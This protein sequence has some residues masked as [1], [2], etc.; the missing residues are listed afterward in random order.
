VG[1]LLVGSKVGSVEGAAVEGV[2]VGGST[3]ILKPVGREVERLA[4]NGVLVFT[5]SDG[6]VGVGTAEGTAVDGKTTGVFF[7]TSVG[8]R[9]DE[10][11]TDGDGVPW[12]GHA[13]GIFVGAAVMVVGGTVRPALNGVRA[14]SVGL[15]TAGVGSVEGITADGTSVI[16][17]VGETVGVVVGI[18]GGDNVATGAHWWGTLVGAKV[19]SGAH[20][21]GAI[22]EGTSEGSNEGLLEGSLVDWPLMSS[23][24]NENTVAIRDIAKADRC[25]L[26]FKRMLG[27]L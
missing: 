5:S 26:R 4:E 7:G 23:A 20:T 8:E 21:L 14:S 27:L 2:S 11:T 9:V 16:L 19:F 3:L 22:N 18:T 15:E 24:S 12:G 17:E 1:E 10:G 25:L 13:I 6:L